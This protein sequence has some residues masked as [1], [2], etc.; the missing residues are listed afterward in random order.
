MVGPAAP[1]PGHDTAPLK[2]NYT[3]LGACLADGTNMSYDAIKLGLTWLTTLLEEKDGA[4]CD[5]QTM[6]WAYYGLG[7]MASLCL[8]NNNFCRLCTRDW[9]SFRIVDSR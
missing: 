1:V 8:L 2:P 3:D 6:P 7:C 5:I 4:S 9:E